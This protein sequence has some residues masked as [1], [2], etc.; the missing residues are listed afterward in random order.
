MVLLPYCI[1]QAFQWGFTISIRPEPM[2]SVY[3]SVIF[4]ACGVRKKGRLLT[5]HNQG[6][7]KAAI[8]NLLDCSRRN[9]FNLE[10]T[11]SSHD[12]LY[13]CILNHPL[14][15]NNNKPPLQ[16]N[17]FGRRYAFIYWK[18]VVDPFEEWWLS[19]AISN[20][21]CPTL[22]DKYFYL[23]LT[24]HLSTAM[25]KFLIKYVLSSKCASCILDRQGA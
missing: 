12:K 20:S 5:C 22:R 9:C 1:I 13:P 14:F 6:N 8:K 25:L 18:S 11:K 15:S 21:I 24:P 2:I 7:K 23:S 4:M 19:I 10:L 3:F 17:M 16:I